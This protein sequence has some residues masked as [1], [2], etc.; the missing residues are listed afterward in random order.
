MNIGWISIVLITFVVMCSFGYLADMIYATWKAAGETKADPFSKLN[1]K[2]LTH[3]Q[4][5]SVDCFGACMKKFAWSVDETSGC[6]SKC[7][8]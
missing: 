5:P 7:K 1:K 4:K 2:G 3:R 6:A 8:A